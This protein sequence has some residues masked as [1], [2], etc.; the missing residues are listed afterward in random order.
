MA[1][2]GRRIDEGTSRQNFHAKNEISQF[3]S[4]M[5]VLYLKRTHFSSRIQI[6][7]KKH[8]SLLKHLKEN[9]IFPFLGQKRGLLGLFDG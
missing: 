2:R 3:L 6:Q 4:H 9:S 1:A 5:N 8:G 7:T